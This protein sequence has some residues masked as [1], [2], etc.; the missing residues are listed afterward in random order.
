MD[1]SI[2][3]CMLF[4]LQ[5]IYWMIGRY[6]S[7]QVKDNQDYFLAGKT[8]QLFPLTMTFLATMVGGGTVLGAA[9]ESFRFGWP[10]VLFPMGTA[11][12]LIALGLGFGRKLAEF[13]VS[14]TSQIFEKAFDSPSLKKIS[15]LLSIISL[16]MILIGQIVGSQKFLLSMGIQNTPLF[17]LFWAI[18]IV[19]TAQGGLKAVI[20]TDL[21]QA[22]FFTCIFLGCFALIAFSE[23][24]VYNMPLPSLET[25]ESVSPKLCGWI[26]L[27]LLFTVL[28]QDMGQRC[29]AGANSKVVSRAALFAGLLGMLVCMI[30][31]FLGI[32]ANTIELTPSN[33]SSVLM[34]VI[35]KTTNPWLTALMGCAVLAA[36]VSTATSLINAISSNLLG[37]FRL[38]SMKGSL[39][40]VQLL[41]CIISVLAV[42]IGL[43]ADN[44]VDLFIQSY[45]LS[46]ACLAVPLFVALFKKQ[47]PR[48]AAIFSVASGATGFIIFQWVELPFPKE[49]AEIALS[50]TGYVLGFIF[51]MVKISKI[52]RVKP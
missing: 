50:A 16:F 31:I 52:K 11:L 4:S 48:E 37:D 23:P 40:P 2:F 26:F 30:P 22:S 7:R 38:E 5:C 9:E 42:F 15:S 35:A 41:T 1:A 47:G 3:I 13:G 20:S 39:R 8:V 19:Y 14:T 21:M 10:V 27:P 49:I 51:W 43:Y 25:F 6:A 44:I 34:A 18:I 45:E 12:G 29:F 28:G 36:I 24:S 17:V 33:G 46:I 32:L